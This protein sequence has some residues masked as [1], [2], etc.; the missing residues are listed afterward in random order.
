[1][2]RQL[3]L[4]IEAQ[5]KYLKKII[6]EQQRISGTLSD[7]PGSG[8]SAPGT[9][10]NCPESDNK[11]DPATPAPTSESPFIEK[12]AVEHASTKSLSLDGSFSS[13]HEPLT[14]DS[15]CHPG[16]PVESPSERPV[17]KKRAGSD[18]AFTKEEM[19]LSQS[20]LESS[21]NSPYQQQHPLFLTSD[22]FDHSSELP[23]GERNQLEKVSGNM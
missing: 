4:R 3:Q 9:E 23:L 8:A 1:M 20:I 7:V 6:E 12:P 14:P 16:S 2:Q 17:K 5:G 11:S 13:H 21:L 19:L 15:G 22:Q 10:D 18:V